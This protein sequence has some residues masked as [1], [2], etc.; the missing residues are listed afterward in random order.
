VDIYRPA[1]LKQLSVLAKDLKLPV[2]EGVPRNEAGE[3]VRGARKE[4]MQTGRDV[5]LVDTAGRLHI[6]EELMT[7]LIELRDQLSPAEILFVA[8][9][10][11]RAGRRE[12]GGR[13]NKRL[14]IT[15]RF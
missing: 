9:C 4:A 12:I 6:D 8:E 14:G 2:Y 13:V 11:D 10:D 1:A 15:V 3:L 5:L 7:E